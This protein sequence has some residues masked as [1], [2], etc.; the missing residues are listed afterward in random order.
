[1]SGQIAEMARNLDKKDQKMND[2]HR[3]MEELLKLNAAA[4][5][6]ADSRASELEKVRK[7]FSELRI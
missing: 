5:T 2:L 1:V 3:R 4:N 7:D 6:L